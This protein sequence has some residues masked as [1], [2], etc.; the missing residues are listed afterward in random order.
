[1]SG[2]TITAS[3]IPNGATTTLTVTYPGDTNH[4]SRTQTKVITLYTKC[5]APSQSGTL[6]YN[7]SS[8]T[9]TFGT[10]TYCSVTSGNTGTNAGSYTAVFTT[11]D[12]TKYRFP[13]ATTTKN[14]S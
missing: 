3:G 7:G 14:V 8:Q 2:T 12:S 1:M 6:T 5:V 13:S 9:A 4:N 11:T 10:A